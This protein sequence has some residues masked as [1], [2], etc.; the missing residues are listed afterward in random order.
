MT[1]PA[2]DEI[3]PEKMS[4]FDYYRHICFTGSATDKQVI[5]AIDRV[6]QNGVSSSYPPNEFSSNRDWRVVVKKSFQE[7]KQL[8]TSR[9]KRGY[10]KA[11]TLYYQYH[12]EL[13]NPRLFGLNK[14]LKEV[15]DEA[16]EWCDKKYL[17][18][19]PGKEGDG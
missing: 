19:E 13:E 3:D 2:N 10:E 17:T 1:K 6:F 4:S 8:I 18:E 12:K 7:I 5:Q 11:K 9:E 14:A 15:L 16:W